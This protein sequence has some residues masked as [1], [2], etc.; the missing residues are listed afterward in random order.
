MCAV[1]VGISY[2]PP[3]PAPRR[4]WYYN[5]NDIV[6]DF[7]RITSF[8]PP[9]ARHPSSIMSLSNTGGAG[10]GGQSASIIGDVINQGKKQFWGVPNMHY[11]QGMS[12]GENTLNAVVARLLVRTL[13][14]DASLP[15]AL[16]AGGGSAYSPAPFLSA[17]VKFMT[18]PSSHNDT[19]AESWHRM[20]FANH[21]AGKAPAA[22]ADDDGH[23]ID[24]AGGLVLLP[25]PSLLAAA[26]AAKKGLVAASAAAAQAAVL[27]QLATHNSQ[28]LVPFTKVY[29]SALASVL[30]APVSEGAAM[31]LARAAKDAGK[32]LR[33]DL[34]KLAASDA[35][36]TRVI[37]GG[38][39]F[40]SACYIEGSLPALF[41]LAAKYADRPAEAVIA[42]TNVGGENCHRGSALGALVGAAHGMDAW[43]GTGWVEAL[44]AGPAIAQEAD[45]FAKSV[46]AAYTAGGVE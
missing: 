33:V 15:R 11:H 1:E 5:P 27:Q 30:L 42:N 26:A 4:H 23:N 3:H 24:S 46:R 44:A 43:K 40:T 8:Q 6:N 32:S 25:P 34:A 9:K 2:P 21:V 41:F 31:S 39:I 35:P 22:C 14:S 37:G 12:A 19:Y 16:A 17:Y 38:G 18:T 7:G 29:A 28:R 10:R 36:D 13:T 45:A 20:F